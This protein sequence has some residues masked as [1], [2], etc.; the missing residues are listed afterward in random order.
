MMYAYYLLF[1]ILGLVFGS[2]A[3]VLITRVPLNKTIGGRSQCPQCKKTLT[4]LELLPVVSY[5]FQRGACSGCKKSISMLYPCIELS[6]AVIFILA[7]TVHAVPWVAL[8]LAFAL[9]LLLVMSVIDI[10]TRTVADALSI[11]FIVLGLLYSL[12][13]GVN[14]ISG[15]ALG[16]GFFGALWL[17]SRGK[18]IGSGDIL[19]GIGIGALLGSWRFV[20]AS[21]VITYVL[22]AFILSVF[23]ITGKISR[24][25]YVPFVPF[26]ALGTYIT[27]ACMPK[28]DEILQLYFYL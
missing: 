2:F 15:I 14:P 27:V 10:E 28:I 17:V 12:F 22:G 18:W 26:L 8:T 6:S 24:K 1:G 11:P 9:W 25:D 13:L 21:Y 23:L 3:S 16:G 19:L 20:L 7:A 4:P 5:V